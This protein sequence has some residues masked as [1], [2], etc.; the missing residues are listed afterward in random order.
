MDVLMPVCGSSVLT[1]IDAVLIARNFR[2]L[3]E[4]ED[5]EKNKSSS[6]ASYG[7]TEADDMTL[8]HWTALIITR[9]RLITTTTATTTTTTTT[10]TIIIRGN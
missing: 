5:A 8:T 4:L 7:L 6:M 9:V 2:L 10:T 1:W 3:A